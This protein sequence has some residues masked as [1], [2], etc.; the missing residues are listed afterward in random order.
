MAQNLVFIGDSITE[1]G[2]RIDDPYDLGTGYV[3]RVARQR[4]AAGA[5]DRVVN[6]GIGGNRAVDLAARWDR[7]CL[8]HDPD[9][10]SIHVGINDTWRRYDGG[11]A[12]STDAFESVY[13]SLVMRSTDAGARLVLIEPFLL[14]LTPEQAT[15]REDLDPKID[16]VRELAREFDA[17]LVEA[18]VA[19]TRAALEGDPAELLWDGVHPTDAGRDLL[20]RTWHETVAI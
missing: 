18:D 5:D 1:D 16:V 4:A 12:T 20:A 3:A 14:A 11:E 15:W 9:L 2:R 10:V 19:F 7:D 8:A 6:S 17:T 13:R